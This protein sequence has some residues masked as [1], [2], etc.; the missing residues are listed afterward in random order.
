MQRS[1]ECDVSDNR[2]VS[3]AVGADSAA[4]GNDALGGGVLACAPPPSRAARQAIVHEATALADPL[5][6]LHGLAH[7]AAAAAARVALP[8]SECM[9][10]ALRHYRGATL[11]AALLRFALRL[12]ECNMRPLYS[13]AAAC[14]GCGAVTTATAAADAASARQRTRGARAS[15]QRGGAH[16]QR[17]R[18]SPAASTAAYAWP[19]W[20]ALAKRREL[21]ADASRLLFIFKE[22]AAGTSDGGS[23]AAREA[24]TR[25]A[26]RSAGSEGGLR[27][28]IA[29]GKRVRAPAS[30]FEPA[31]AAGGGARGNGL[32]TDSAASASTPIAFAS[33]RFVLEELGDADGY[34]RP[35]RDVADAA[36]GT[37]AF[38]DR[39]SNEV[40]RDHGDRGRDTKRPRRA[41][42]RTEAAPAVDTVA[43]ATASEPSSAHADACTAVPVLY[44]YEIHCAHAYRRLGLGTL[45]VRA[46]ER[47]AD[48]TGMHAM[49]LTCLEN[50][51]AALKWYSGAGDGASRSNAPASE[52]ASA[53]S[54]AAPDASWHCGALA[55]GTAPHSPPTSLAPYRI[56]MKPTRRARAALAASH[57]AT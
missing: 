48:A 52:C 25:S 29:T 43:G 4:S 16:N 19:A 54:N 34:I 56:L 41:A 46:L 9:R 1:P 36:C 35:A 32:P 24:R 47:I 2:R 22:D 5:R 51:T 3:D 49:M 30:T 13:Q 17:A 50:N 55:F 7:R 31:A 44:L 23:A 53:D 37:R 40:V 10:L 8:R 42:A 20:S 38:V 14:S 27:A 45:L 12:T 21:A 28:P 26:G 11:P 15:A 18:A 33:Y 39:G 6:D 57:A